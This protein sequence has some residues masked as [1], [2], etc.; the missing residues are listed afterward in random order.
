MPETNTNQQ[1]PGEDSPA[2]LAYR[3]GQL[4]KSTAA[5]FKALGEKLDKMSCTFVTFKDLD[6]AIADAGIAHDM[7]QKDIKNIQKQKWV[8]NTLSILFGAVLTLLVTYAFTSIFK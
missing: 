5:G 8:Q 1:I 6:N 2:V 7:L 4:E 3:V